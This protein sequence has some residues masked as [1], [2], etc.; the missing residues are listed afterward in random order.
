M[1]NKKILAFGASSSKNSINK[2]LAS[3]AAES[4]DNAEVNIVDLND[5]EMPIYSVDKE[6]DFGIPELALNFKKLIME[7]DGLIISF[8]EH[9]GAYSVAFKNVLDWIS[10]IER[11]TWGN[12]SM[13]LMATSP[14]ARGGQTVLEIAINRFKYMGGDVVASFS[15][16]S[17]GQNFSEES[18]ITDQELLA[19]FREQLQVFND[20]VWMKN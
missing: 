9:N 12:K 18:G 8:A 17:F 6:N 20:A 2:K 16:P 5:Y 7:S 4:M 14:G 13:F 1:K 19:G 10:R 3:W 11:D 15:L